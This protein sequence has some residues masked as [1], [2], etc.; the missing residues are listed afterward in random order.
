MRA[1]PPVGS[2]SVVPQMLQ[3][4][5]V[6]ARLNTFKFLQEHS[7]KTYKRAI[8][9]MRIFTRKALQL[10]VLLEDEENRKLSE[11]ADE[12]QN[13][14]SENLDKVYEL[15]VQR[16]Q[17]IAETM[18]LIGPAVAKKVEEFTQHS[19][20]IQD[21]L[22]PEITASVE[23]TTNLTAIASGVAILFAV[24]A[25]FVIGRSI[26]GPISNM[27]QAMEQLA[28]GNLEVDIPAQGNTDEVG[29]MADAVTIF[30]DNALEVKKLQDAQEKERAEAEEQRRQLLISMADNFEESIKE[31]VLVVSDS[32]NTQSGQAQGLVGV[33]DNASHTAVD[34]V[35]AAEHA[36]DNVQTVAV[37]AE[38]LSASIGEISRQVAHSSTIAG[39]AADE[40][41]KTNQQVQGLSVAANKIGEV[42]GLI[43]DIAEQT[44]LLALNATI[45]AARAGDA[46]K[47]FAVVANEVK[48]LA[49]QTARAT[50][51]ISAQIAGIQGATD[52]AVA[53]IESIGVTITSV[54][55]ISAA[56]AA[57]VEQ[58]GAATQEIAANVEQAHQGTTEVVEKITTVKGAADETGNTANEISG[59]ASGLATQ[60]DNLREDVERFISHIR[61]S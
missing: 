3:R 21:Q 54:N 53:A 47:G 22:G 20:G 2:A 18:D 10:L 36:A 6:L 56:I 12:L 41:D 33:S 13:K 28:E 8:K 11:E 4:T 59:A 32:A 49:S 7:E 45:E 52:E 48:S 38:E 58:Q 42:V 23:N 43:T 31:V 27:T 60:A 30:R 44:N 46:G 39:Q 25:A 35:K 17:I 19:R 61:D 51:E 55:E 50:E 57:A 29:H 5:S 26:S 14:Y 16:N 40:A 9:E 37:A 1:A 24:I 15:T 34:A